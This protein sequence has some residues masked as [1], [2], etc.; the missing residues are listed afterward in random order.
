MT[1]RNLLDEIYSRRNDF[2][3][4]CPLDKMSVYEMSWILSD[5]AVC[6]SAPDKNGNRDNLGIL[7]LIYL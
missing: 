6:P 7:F 2:S 3:T 5:S 4:K 1:F